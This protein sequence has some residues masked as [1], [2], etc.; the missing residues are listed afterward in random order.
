MKLPSFIT[1]LYWA[2]K[3]AHAMETGRWFYLQDV[4][5]ALVDK[6]ASLDSDDEFVAAA[7]Q[8][9]QLRNMRLALQQSK[10]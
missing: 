8:E 9:Q 6:L 7:K 4:P 10:L 2:F 3:I 1:E 5:D